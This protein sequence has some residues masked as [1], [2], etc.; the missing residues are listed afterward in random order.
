MIIEMSKKHPRVIIWDIETSSML[1]KSWGLWNQNINYH[2]IVQDWNIYCISWK[3]LGKKRVKTFS[4]DLNVSQFDDYDLCKKMREVLVKADAIV[5][6]NGNAFDLKK[7][8][9]RLIKHK[10]DPLPPIQTIDTLKEA[11]KIAKFSSNKLDYIGQYLGCG[12]KIETAGQNLWKGV[13]NGDP[14]SLKLMIKYC[15]QDVRLLENVYLKLRG[16]MKSHPNLSF[17]DDKISCPTC[18]SKNKMKEGTRRTASGIL[19]QRYKCKD[20]YRIYSLRVSEK[21]KSLTQN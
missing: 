21:T 4:V 3:V 7:Y 10:L 16:Y 14:R 8:N 1:V 13:Y 19:K 5:H 2:D 11:R 9:A 20:C 6:H 15:E 12:E 18:N 17:Y